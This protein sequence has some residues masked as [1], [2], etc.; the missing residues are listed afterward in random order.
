[1]C[2]AP[3]TPLLFFP[4]FSREDDIMICRRGLRG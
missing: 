4:C 1:V 2:P 3:F